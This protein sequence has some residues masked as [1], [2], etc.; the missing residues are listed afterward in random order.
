MYLSANRFSMAWE[1]GIQSDAKTK[2]EKRNSN[3]FF[4]VMRKRKTKTEIQ[5]P[6]SKC[7]ENEIQIRFSMSQVDKKRK[8][9]MGMEFHF[10]GPKK[11]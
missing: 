4:K 2:H 8:I 1:K 10:T 11:K 7:G 3:P 9:E 5:I 6:F